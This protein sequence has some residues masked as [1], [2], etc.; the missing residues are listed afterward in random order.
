[1]KLLISCNTLGAINFLSRTWGG[2]RVSDIEH[3][4]KRE[5]L[6]KLP[7]HPRDQILADRGFTIKDEFACIA[8]VE[9]L[10]PS[11]I[12]GRDQFSAQDLETSRSLSSVRIHIERV[13]GLLKNTRFPVF[14]GP[15]T[16]GSI[17]SGI[18]HD[19]SRVQS[20]IIFSPASDTR[21]V[22]RPIAS[23]ENELLI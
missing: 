6:T 2:G 23:P 22:P 14:K 11:F 17:Q 12:K 18:P 21:E 13:I 5:F 9:L 20:A 7:H 3:V 16:L 8:D 1:M 4:N 10:T 19:I 15:F